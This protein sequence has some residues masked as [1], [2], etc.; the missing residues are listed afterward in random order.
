MGIHVGLVVWIWNVIDD[1]KPVLNQACN[2]VQSCLTTKTT[3]KQ[4]WF[5]YYPLDTRRKHS[6]YKASKEVLECLLKSRPVSW[7][8]RPALSLYLFL[9]LISIWH[10]YL[11]KCIHNKR[12][13]SKLFFEWYK[14]LIKLNNNTKWLF[15]SKK[16]LKSFC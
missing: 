8:Q 15:C 6:V 9:G 4:Q 2:N 5:R 14:A 1:D 3:T 12:E 13:K 10:L 7:W 16:I 11:W